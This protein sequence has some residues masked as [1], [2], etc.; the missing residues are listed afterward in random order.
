M[1]VEPRLS[2]RRRVQGALVLALM[3]VG[4]LAELFTIGAV[5]PFLAVFADPGG[6]HKTS[7]FSAIF[8][9]LGLSPGNLR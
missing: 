2:R 8:A 3:F 1:V 9:G 5:I 6:L 7:R 4:A